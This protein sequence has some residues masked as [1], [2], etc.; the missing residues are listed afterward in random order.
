VTLDL[1]ESQQTR[2][3]QLGSTAEATAQRNLMHS[4]ALLADMKA[5]KAANPGCML[6]DFVRWHSPRD[7]IADDAA[8]HGV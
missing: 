7:W 5:F 2:M 8:P 3:A 6:A 1:I 4:D